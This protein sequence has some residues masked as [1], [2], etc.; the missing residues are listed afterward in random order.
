MVND[1]VSLEF[2]LCDLLCSLKHYQESSRE[3]QVLTETRY[4]SESLKP[5]VTETSTT[6]VPVGS[7]TVRSV[8][9]PL[10]LTTSTRWT[11]QSPWVGPPP[12]VGKTRVRK[13]GLSRTDKRLLY[14]PNYLFW[15]YTCC[16]SPLWP[17]F[18]IKKME[19][20][21]WSVNGDLGWDFWRFFLFLS[22]YLT[23]DNTSCFDT[24]FHNKGSIDKDRS[25]KEQ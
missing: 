14:G 17:K 5:T 13:E 18:V 22:F 1:I 6:K 19:C 2:C 15:S 23:G 20:R 21:T 24:N 4:T 8:V 10:F 9:L 16:P 11:F 25:I 7:I 12:W 3:V